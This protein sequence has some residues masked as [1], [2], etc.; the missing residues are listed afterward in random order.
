MKTAVITGG[1]GFV[2]RNLSN[3]LL[4]R[5]WQVIAT[6][7]RP[8]PKL[9]NHDNFRYV[10]ADTTVAGAW[11]DIFED[12]DAVI[13]LAGRTIFNYWTRQYKKAIFESRVLTTQNLVAA[14]PDDREITL[15]SASAGGFYGDRGD[16]LLTESASG[17]NDFLADVCKAWEHEALSAKLKGIRS[18]VARFGVVLDKSGGAMEKM[19]LPFRFCLGGPLGDGRQWFPWIHLTD[20]L[21]AL[22]FI[23]KTPAI[24]GPVNFVAP[25]PIRYRDFA[26]SLGRALHRPAF[27]PVPALLL[28]MVL[29]GFGASLLGSQ[30]MLPEKLLEQGFSFQYLDLEDAFNEIIAR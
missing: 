25:H 21:A 11:Q 29:G 26:A 22:V 1:L 17:G 28:K 16:T 19:M 30:R 8:S 18:V 20:L 12:V 7:T 24:S 2:G 15:I 6:G 4:N 23:L 13:N 5:G 3:Y 9:I 10:A 27:M 14:L